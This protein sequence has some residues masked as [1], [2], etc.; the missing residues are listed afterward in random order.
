MFGAL[1]KSHEQKALDYWMGHVFVVLI[2]IKSG[3]YV[4]S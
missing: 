2:V 1:C 4:C 3:V